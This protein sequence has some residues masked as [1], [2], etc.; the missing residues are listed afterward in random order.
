MMSLLF[1][2]PAVIVGFAIW[3]MPIA[4][5]EDARIAE[6]MRVAKKTAQDMVR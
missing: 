4:Q 2:V 3:Y 5:A 6:A 1:L